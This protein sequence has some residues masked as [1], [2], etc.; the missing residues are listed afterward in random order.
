MKILPC[1][2]TVMAMM[3]MTGCQ[4]PQL[5]SADGDG[6]GAATG[7]GHGAG[8]CFSYPK[9]PQPPL[10]L[11]WKKR[12]EAAFSRALSSDGTH[13]IVGLQNGS[14]EKYGIVSG[15]RVLRKRIMRQSDA[16]AAVTGYCIIAALRH[17]SPSLHCLDKET[18]K[19]A[20][21][22]EA[23]ALVGEPLILGDT[24]V[25][26][27]ASGRVSAYA[28]EQGR[29]LGDIQLNTHLLNGPSA[30]ANTI[31]VAGGEGGLWALNR[32]DFTLKWRAQLSG[33]TAAAPVVRNHR[34]FIGTL[35]ERFHAVSC[36]NG[37]VLWSAHT[38]GNVFETASAQGGV[39]YAPTAR[40]VL[41][42]LEQETGRM[43]WRHNAHSVI[44][45][46][47]LLVGGVLYYGTLDHHFRAVNRAN[48]TMLW[49]TTLQGRIR[50]TPLV[51]GPWLIIA[52]EGRMLYGFQTMHR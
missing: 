25:V 44:G 49:E 18:L 4:P 31:Y 47:P 33:R 9:G 2:I 36:E 39:V 42:A 3:A 10:A 37:S 24:V 14:L 50:N 19:P 5:S 48:G 43:L 45:T 32:H 28:L 23:G 41:W 6:I 30:D 38:E 8:R 17:K 29:C 16:T 22:A 20:W 34:L 52:S 51:V 35:D 13:V 1:M 7:W 21:T 27:S 12:T 15:K 46:S 11:Q 26:A 40:G